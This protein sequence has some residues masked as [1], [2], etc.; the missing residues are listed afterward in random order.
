MGEEAGVCVCAC[1]RMYMC[2]CVCAFEPVMSC[3][4]ENCDMSRSI[5]ILFGINRSH[6]RMS[7]Y[8]PLHVCVYVW[9]R[10]CE[11]L[12]SVNAATHTHTHTH[13]H[14]G[15]AQKERVIATHQ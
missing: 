8:T 5:T 2:V 11:Q 12:V 13:T 9:G 1:V 14:T 7:L 6:L 3:A 4:M 10:G 15:S